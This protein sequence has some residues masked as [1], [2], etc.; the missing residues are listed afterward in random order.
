[1]ARYQSHQSLKIST[2]TTQ[3]HEIPYQE[4]PESPD[5]PKSLGQCQGVF[6]ELESISGIFL[7]FHSVEFLGLIADIVNGYMLV[8]NIQ[9][10]QFQTETAQYLDNKCVEK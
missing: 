1:M 9:Y 4:S 8:Q 3:D 5:L 7:L 10:I 6:Y 2:N